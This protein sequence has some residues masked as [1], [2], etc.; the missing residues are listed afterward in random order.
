VFGIKR[1]IATASRP[2][3]IAFVKELG[4]TDVIDHRVDLGP[5][6]KAL[7]IEPTLV[8]INHDTARYVKEL[9][10]HIAPFGQIGSVVGSITDSI[11]IHGMTLWF[12]SISFHWELQQTRV[13]F[14]RNVETH[15]QIVTQ[16]AQLR[17]AGTLKNMVTKRETFSLASLRAAHDLQASGTIIGKIAFTFPEVLE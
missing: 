9:E 1:V 13:M 14:K 3:T 15:G 16:L 2:E 10:E 17:A 5:Q 6:L 8:F 7:G 11:P 12:R 4:A